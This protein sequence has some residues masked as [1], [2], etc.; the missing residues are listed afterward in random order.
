MIFLQPTAKNV[1][2]L[3]TTSI[4]SVKPQSSKGKKAEVWTLSERA[5][6]KTTRFGRH[7]KSTGKGKPHATTS[8]RTKTTQGKVTVKAV[9]PHIPAHKQGSEC[10]RWKRDEG[11]TPS[12]IGSA[13][14]QSRGRTL[15]M[16]CKCPQL[17][18]IESNVVPNAYQDNTPLSAPTSENR[19]SGHWTTQLLQLIQ[20]YAPPSRD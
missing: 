5:L 4:G 17:A 3:C 20:E 18:Y 11:P 2:R 9:Q 12:K 15:Q 13:I 19:M 8:M 16:L 7:R 14:W 10:Q 6:Q 1:V